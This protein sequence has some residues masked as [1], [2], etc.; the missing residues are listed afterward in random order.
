MSYDYPFP[1][2]YPDPHAKA[3]PINRVIQQPK[4]KKQALRIIGPPF[5]LEDGC[6][7]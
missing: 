5:R 4:F 7:K 2:F 3:N 6:N 1:S